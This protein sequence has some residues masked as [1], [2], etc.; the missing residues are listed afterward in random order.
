MENMITKW[1]SGLK[2]GM[3]FLLLLLSLGIIV[4]VLCTFLLQKMISINTDR[5]MNCC[6]N[7]SGK[8]LS[9]HKTVK[10]NQHDFAGYI[11]KIQSRIN[12]GCFISQRLVNDLTKNVFH[13]NLSY[14]SGIT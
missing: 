4:L 2:P 13:S 11:N 9:K 12:G 1:T 14:R 10:T 6:P 8:R 5:T 3:L 7:A